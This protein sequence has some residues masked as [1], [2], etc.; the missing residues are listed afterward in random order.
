SP[1]ANSK[2]RGRPAYS[3]LE[4]KHFDVSVNIKYHKATATLR[5]RY[6][7]ELDYALMYIQNVKQSK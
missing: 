4:G 2:K 6:V 5:L 7:P 3:N 1:P